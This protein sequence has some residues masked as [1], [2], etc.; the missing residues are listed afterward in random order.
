MPIPAFTLK[1]VFSEL[2]DR[3]GVKLQWLVVDGEAMNVGHR[4]RDEFEKAAAKA[5]ASGEKEF[6]SSEGG[7]YRHAGPIRL[8]ND[9]LKCHVPSRISTEDRT[10]GLVIIMPIKPN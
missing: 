6:E 10:A 4:P 5:L 2:E 3:S 8:H 1:H 9:C 7:V